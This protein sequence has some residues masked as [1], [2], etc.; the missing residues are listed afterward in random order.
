MKT[1]LEIK[2]K[3]LSLYAQRDKFKLIAISEK[4]KTVELKAAFFAV[5][6]Y[7]SEKISVLHWVLEENKSENGL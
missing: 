1:E 5:E 6:N 2:E 7:Y 3:L 4:Q